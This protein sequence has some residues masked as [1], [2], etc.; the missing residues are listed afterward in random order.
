MEWKEL[1]GRREV[2]KEV[3]PNKIFLAEE[4]LEKLKKGERLF[5][6][7]YWVND[8]IHVHVMDDETFYQLVKEIFCESCDERVIIWR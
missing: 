2:V 6:S 1:V 8:T 5:A 3:K 4:E 7:V